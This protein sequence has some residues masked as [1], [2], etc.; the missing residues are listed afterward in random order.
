MYLSTVNELEWSCVFPVFVTVKAVEDGRVRSS[1][2]HLQVTVVIAFYH[3]GHA[4]RHLYACFLGK[5]TLRVAS[6][7]RHH[8]EA[9]CY[10][11]CLQFVFFHRAW[12]AACVAQRTIVGIKTKNCL[13]AHRDVVF[14]NQFLQMVGVCHVLCSD[15]QGRSRHL[16]ACHENEA[17]T[18]GVGDGNPAYLFMVT[19]LLRLYIVHPL[20]GYCTFVYAYWGGILAVYVVFPWATS[21]PTHTLEAFGQFHSIAHTRNDFAVGYRDDDTVHHDGTIGIYG[22][23]YFCAILKTEFTFVAVPDV[24]DYSVLFLVGFPFAGFRLQLVKAF[25]LPIATYLFIVVG[26]STE[27]VQ[28]ESFTYQGDIIQ[29]ICR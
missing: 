10:G 2:T 24:Q 6:F 7:Q 11:S 15:M 25:A 14:V 18:V 12:T 27:E 29:C 22:V 9:E 19:H 4:C 13:L 8:D 17:H 5:L 28:F 26:G 21:I 3:Y 23:F 1:G 16:V 20:V